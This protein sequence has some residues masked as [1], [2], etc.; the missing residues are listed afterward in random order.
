VWKNGQGGI[1]KLRCKDWGTEG[2]AGGKIGGVAGAKVANVA[3]QKD[4]SVEE[5]LRAIVNGF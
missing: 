3:A 5:L 2:E 1:A 4:I